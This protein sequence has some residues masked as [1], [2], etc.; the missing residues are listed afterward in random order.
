MIMRATLFRIIGLF[1]LE[2]LTWFR[3]VSGQSVLPERWEGILTQTGGRD[4]F[5]LAF[6]LRQNGDLITGQSVSITPEKKT[7]R[8][9]IAGRWD[10]QTLLVQEIEQLE[11]GKERWCLK[12]FTL[13]RSHDISSSWTLSGAWKAESCPPGMA[14]LNPSGQELPEEEAKEPLFSLEGSWTGHLSQ[15]D[16]D[17]GFYFE[18]DLHPEGKGASSIVSEAN[19]GQAFHSLNWTFLP[20]DS[21]LEFSE[22]AILRKTS[23]TWKWCIK[24]ARLRLS[25]Q[26]ARYV[27]EG[28][29]NGF[30]EGRTPATGP[31]APGK[32][33]LE[34]PI[35][36]GADSML[37]SNPMPPDSLG[38]PARET[39]IERQI[40][41]YRPDLKIKVW[42]NG[43]EDGDV[44]SL[45]LNGKRIAHRFRITKGKASVQVKLQQEFNLLVLY[46]ED[47][48]TIVPNTVAIS[49]D[50]GVKEHVL[51]LN[52]DLAH[53]GAVL[54]RQFSVKQ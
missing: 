7:G 16:R 47:I 42:D 28:E 25:R 2:T 23:P 50:D 30:I 38:T 10:G 6:Q 3:P 52:A 35:L 21:I 27:M 5:R 43:T 9:S 45:F 1:T 12:Y 46:A 24:N 13:Q 32:L 8:F 41:V 14:Y 39:K 44:I 31:C 26:G 4:T 34:K 48:G 51:V 15:V 19:G 33:Y 18:M 20:K 49:I 36:G 17:Y 11:P 29:W 22:L 54:I 40:D 53:N 37:V